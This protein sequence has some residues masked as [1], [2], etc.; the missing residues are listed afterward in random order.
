MTE[1]QELTSHF[2][3]NELL[4]MVQVIDKRINKISYEVNEN[5]EEFA[6][7]H[8]LYSDNSGYRVRLRIT[9]DS[10]K[11]IAANVLKHI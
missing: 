4:K 10:L 1:K 11:A 3:S 5:E 6:E 9:G 2:I 8:W 7:V